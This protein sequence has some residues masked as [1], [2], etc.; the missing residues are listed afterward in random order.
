MKNERLRVVICEDGWWLAW[1]LNR[2][3]PLWIPESVQHW[4]VRK[5]NSVVC[6]FYG[7]QIVGMIRGTLCSHCMHCCEETTGAG[8]RW[9]ELEDS[10]DKR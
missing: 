3:L 7:H 5:W 9:C 1:G 4:I 8:C 10:H 2:G 6:Y